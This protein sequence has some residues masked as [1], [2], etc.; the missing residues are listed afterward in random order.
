MQNF[1][2][3]LNLGRAIKEG[4]LQINKS[5][6]ACMPRQQVTKVGKQISIFEPSLKRS[7]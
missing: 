1:I 2:L 6:P 7:K 3:N 5:L 4:E